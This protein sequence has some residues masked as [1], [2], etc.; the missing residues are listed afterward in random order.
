MVDLADVF[1][2]MWKENHRVQSCFYN[3]KVYV[4]KGTFAQALWQQ[5]GSL[6]GRTTMMR[7]GYADAPGTYG[8]EVN[9]DEFMQSMVNCAHEHGMQVVIHAIGDD[10]IERVIKMYETA[11]KGG[12]N[13]MR[14]SIIH[15]QITD[16]PLM[17]RIRDA[18]LLIAYQPIFLQYDL[19]VVT[20]RCG[21]ELTS[22]SYAFKTAYDLGIHASYGTDAPVE[23]LN[24]FPCIYCAVNRKDLKGQPEQGFHTHECVDVETAI[25]AYTIESAYHEFRENVKGRLKK[26]Y[27][28]DLVVLDQDIFTCDSMDILNIKPVLTMVGGKIVYQK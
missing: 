26:G 11:N 22:T 2:T 3:A 4:E 21:E 16:K 17:E 19:H 23:D 1:G 7:N 24:P 13:P 20:D 28:A 10:A 15:C 18:S 9:S 27:Y 8:V 25:D 14:H 6:G 5:D 12:D